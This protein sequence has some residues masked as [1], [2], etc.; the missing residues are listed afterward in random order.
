MTIHSAIG[1][2][3]CGCDDPRHLENMLTV[4]QAAATARSLVSPVRETEVV[5]L[6]K[7]SGRVVAENITAPRP[8]PFFD[9]SAMD[10]FAVRVAD[11]EGQGPWRLTVNQTVAAGDR[12]GVDSWKKGTAKRIYTGAPVPAGADAVV[13]IEDCTDEGA[14]VTLGRRPHSGEN[15]RPLGSDIERD[16]L[17]AV[18]GTWIEPRHIGLLAANGFGDLNVYRRPRVGIFST[19]SELVSPAAPEEGRIFDA[20][21]PVLIA[22]A[23]AAGAE[24]V[25]LGIVDDDHEATVR[26]F[27]RHADKF[28]ML[29]SSGAVSAGG[30]DFVR[31]AF[32]RAGGEIRAWK[33]A[34]KPGK[35]ALFGTLGRTAY[36]G[37]PGNPLAAF[38]GFEL[39]VREQILRLGGVSDPRGGEMPARAG[40]AA[41]RKTGRTEYVPARIVSHSPEGLPVVEALGNGSSGTL[42]A[43]GLADGLAV[44][45]ADTQ[46]IAPGDA[47]GFLPF[48]QQLAGTT[49]G[50][51]T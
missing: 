15:I 18:A 4:A 46:Q 43:L 51:F 27:S 29:L 23:E 36:F 19:G 38:V 6:G 20:N 45:S 16:A 37:L 31:S 28:D 2:S 11:L 49:N 41:R 42:Y 26:F 44:I 9:Q 21:R 22:L 50:D 40:Y 30:R 3:R 8:M 39:F 5:R 1:T 32:A 48:C 34:L 14:C 17:L 7:A 10:G 25:D 13:V 33:V 12:S 24:V 47:L 35:P